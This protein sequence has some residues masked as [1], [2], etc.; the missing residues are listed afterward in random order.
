MRSSRKAGYRPPPEERE[1]P[2]EYFGTPPPPPVY[3]LGSTKS[4]NN[5]YHTPPPPILHHNREFAEGF[6]EGEE[7]VE[8]YQTPPPPYH[9]PYE[10]DKGNEARNR[11]FHQPPPFPTSLSGLL[12]GAETPPWERQEG[13]EVAF[14]GPQGEP[15]QPPW[16]NQPPQGNLGFMP[17]IHKVSWPPREPGL[18]KP[19]AQNPAQHPEESLQPRELEY[20]QYSEQQ[21]QSI[22][23]ENGEETEVTPKPFKPSVRAFLPFSQRIDPESAVEPKSNSKAPKRKKPKAPWSSN[24]RARTHTVKT[25]AEV[26]HVPQLFAKLAKP[27]SSSVQIVSNNAGQ[28]PVSSIVNF[29]RQ[30]YLNLVKPGSRL[31]R[32][33]V[34]APYSG[35]QDDIVFALSALSSIIIGSVLAV[36]S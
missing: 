33:D 22:E 1:G 17:D 31:P 14:S 3:S 4:P 36:P 18:Y 23:E 28:S 21:G 34:A 19:P 35:L 6:R 15:T 26:R 12:S 13:Q 30:S 20:S 10:P 25:K 8:Y 27:R 11:D 24:R 7:R 32:A 16:E 5:Y 9:L 29:L 2:V